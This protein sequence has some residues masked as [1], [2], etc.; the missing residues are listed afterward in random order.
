LVPLA[1]EL[2]LLGLLYLTL[3]L[4]LLDRFLDLT[5]ID[6]LEINDQFDDWN[7]CSLNKLYLENLTLVFK[8]L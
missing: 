5:L 3:S 8:E 7:V 6:G 1:W 4:N 2:E